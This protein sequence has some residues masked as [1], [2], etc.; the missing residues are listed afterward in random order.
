MYYPK[1][2]KQ[3]FFGTTKD[4]RQITVCKVSVSDRELDKMI[5]PWNLRKLVAESITK[6]NTGIYDMYYNGVKCVG[7]ATC[8]TNDKYELAKG[9]NIAEIRA[10]ALLS[11]RLYKWTDY[12]LDVIYKYLNQMEDQTVIWMDK[13]EDWEEKAYGFAND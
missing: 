13:H 1:V 8:S 3:F 9:M 6:K 5:T 7:K 2:D 12:A 4:G 11:F 10:M